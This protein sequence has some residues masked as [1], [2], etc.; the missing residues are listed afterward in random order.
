MYLRGVAHFAR[1]SRGRRFD[2][3]HLGRDADRFLDEHLPQCACPY[4][5][6]R[7]RHQVRA[8]LRQL[9]AV[10]ADAGVQ[11]DDDRRDP[12]ELELRR[13]DEHML[14]AKGLAESTRLRR[15]S[16]IRSLMR[17]TASV[18]PTAVTGGG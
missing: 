1:W 11:S 10:F 15:L 12:I 5:V 8:A 2:L 9:R 16:V 7:C 13:F 18:M 4:P 14:Q 6:Q 3:G 17:Q